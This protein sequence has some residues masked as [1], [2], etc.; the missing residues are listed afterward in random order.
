MDEDYPKTLLELE[1]RFSTE[2]A[3]VEYLGALRWPGG[4]ACPRCMGGDAWS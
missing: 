4:W 3:C 2:E 1:R